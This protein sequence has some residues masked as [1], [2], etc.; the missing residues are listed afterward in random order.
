ME[1]LLLANNFRCFASALF[2][3]R[4]HWELGAFPFFAHILVLGVFFPSQNDAEISLLQISHHL[5]KKQ[6]SHLKTESLEIP[7]IDAKHGSL[8]IKL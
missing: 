1:S 5:E 8:P 6:I 3:T 7:S 4:D 2:N